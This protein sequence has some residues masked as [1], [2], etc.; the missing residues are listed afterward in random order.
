MSHEYEDVLESVEAQIDSAVK[1]LVAITDLSDGRRIALG[2]IEN[3]LAIEHH[4]RYGKLEA[5]H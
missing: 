4:R 3:A 2:M 5:H 1:L